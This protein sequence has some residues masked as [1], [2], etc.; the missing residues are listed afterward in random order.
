VNGDQIIETMDGLKDAFQLDVA[1]NIP[2]T[3]GTTLAFWSCVTG[4]AEA[5]A[6]SHLSNPI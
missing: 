2:V 4:Y 5:L 3:D 1:G 6:L